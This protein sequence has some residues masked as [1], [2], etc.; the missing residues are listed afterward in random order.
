M[1]VL[2]SGVGGADTGSGAGGIGTGHAVVYFGEVSGQ[3]L[4]EELAGEHYDQC[5]R[6]RFVASLW[7]DRVEQVSYA[8]T[9]I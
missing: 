6:V 8:S 3:R 1:F 4:G 9:L 7:N 2:G 5:I